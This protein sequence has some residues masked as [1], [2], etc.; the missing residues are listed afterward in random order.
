MPDGNVYS[1]RR[2]GV[3]S[4][5]MFTQMVDT[6][7]NMIVMEY[8]A[9]IYSINWYRYLCFGDDAW[10]VTDYYDNELLNRLISQASDLGMTISAEKSVVTEDIWKPV[11]FLG[12]WDLKQG[13]PLRETFTKLVY[14]ER[15]NVEMFTPAGLLTRFMMYSAE[16]P[17]ADAYL[18]PILVALSRAI[19]AGTNWFIPEDHIPGILL[20]EV[21]EISLAMRDV[22]ELPGIIKLLPASMTS[23]YWR[24]RKA[25]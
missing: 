24:I 1:G 10:L 19:R 13:R 9:D 23:S 17:D 8:C 20:E 15:R 7:I 22:R 25:T 14:P 6:V 3:P 11:I 2:G 4:G 21:K 12:H 18:H 5:S 16:N